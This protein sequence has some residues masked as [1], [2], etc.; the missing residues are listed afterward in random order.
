VTAATRACDQ[1]D[2]GTYI[3]VPIPWRDLDSARA[4]CSENCTG[5]FVIV[6]G[7][8]VASERHDDAALAALS[9][10]AEED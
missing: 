4:W 1:H 5:D 8:R 7:Q 10:R 2:A 9:W 6:L 3:S